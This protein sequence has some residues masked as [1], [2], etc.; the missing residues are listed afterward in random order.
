MTIADEERRHGHRLLKRRTV[1]VSM[2][3]T[4]MMALQPAIVDVAFAVVQA[5]TPQALIGCWNSVS[6]PDQRRY[7]LQL[8]TVGGMFYASGGGRPLTKCGLRV[9]TVAPGGVEFTVQGCEVTG[10]ICGQNP[11]SQEGAGISAHTC[12][13]TNGPEHRGSM[14]FIRCQVP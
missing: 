4:M 13:F 9:V 3:V 1:I 7:S 6:K 2:W 14:R 10:A 8:T 5:R 11:A 12:S